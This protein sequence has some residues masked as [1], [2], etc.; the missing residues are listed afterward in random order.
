MFKD[1]HIHRLLANEYTSDLLVASRASLNTSGAIVF[2]APNLSCFFVSAV[3]VGISTIPKS[4]IQYL[5][6]HTYKLSG[7]ISRCTYPNVWIFSNV[8]ASIMKPSTFCC[9]ISSRNVV[10]GIAVCCNFTYL[11]IMLLKLLANGMTYHRSSLS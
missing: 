8:S 3:F 11:S 9:K 7:F 6:F 1:K 5:P 4:P 2:H 10:T